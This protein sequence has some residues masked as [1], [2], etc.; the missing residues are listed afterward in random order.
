[1]VY[2][3]LALAFFSLLV[4]LA[5][6]LAAKGACTSLTDGLRD[7]RRTESNNTEKL[8][9][10]IAVLRKLVAMQLDGGEVTS[11]ML[12][13]GRTWRDVGAT[14]ALQLI[15]S[16]EDVTVV[17]VRTPQEVAESGTLPGARH[18]PVDQLEERKSELPRKGKMLIYC[19][20]GARSAAACDFLMHAGYEDLYNLEGGFS[21]WDGPVERPS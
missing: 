16:D 8:E 3:A 20:A 5:A 7:I 21:N 15:E 18:L 17:D 6:L 11:D 14:Q 2:V 9:G 1:M 13:E 10:E 12:L 4:G 19:A